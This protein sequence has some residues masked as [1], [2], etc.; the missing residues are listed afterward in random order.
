MLRGLVPLSGRY[1]AAGAELERR[2]PACPFLRNEPRPGFFPLPDAALRRYILP[3]SLW[4]IP[5]HASE[6]FDQ[7][8]LQFVLPPSPP[9]LLLCLLLF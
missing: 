1:G 6:A 3:R 8:T 2:Q 4:P 9:S 5:Q 7:N